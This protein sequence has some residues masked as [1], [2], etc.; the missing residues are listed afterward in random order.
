MKIQMSSPLSLGLYISHRDL[1]DK[2]QIFIPSKV[3]GEIRHPW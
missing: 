1:P 2:D 3:I